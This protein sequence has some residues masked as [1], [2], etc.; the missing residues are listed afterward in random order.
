MTSL[1]AAPSVWLPP[2]VQEPR[3]RCVPTC[4]A[5]AG[6]EA[7]Q[8]YE[9][10]GQS[11]DQWQ[12]SALIDACGE[13]EDGRWAS[14]EVGLEVARQ[15]GKDE[16]LAARE[17]AGLFVWGERLLVHSAHKFDT[18]MEHLE[19]LATLIEGAPDFSRRVR[20]VN[21]S[22][23]SEGITLMDGA[24]IRFR[25][26]TRGGGARGYTGDC[27]IFNEA[28]DLPDA[29]IGAIMPILSARSVRI[30][31]PQIWLAG[32]AVD[33]ETMANGLVLARVR[34]AGIA[35]D[36]ERLTYL[37]YS[38]SLIDWMRA[39]G[40]E[41]DPDRGSELEQ[42]TPA[43]LADPEMWAQANP[44]LGKRI[45]HEHVATELRS[46]SMTARQFAIERLGV[47]DWPEITD[48][49][50][51]VITVEKW[52]ACACTDETK[53]IEGVK[54]FAVDVNPSRTWGSL[55]VAGRREDLVLADGIERAQ[56]H[57]AI[58][59]HERQTD[60]II[61]KEPDGTY[62]G[63]AVELNEEHEGCRFVMDPYGPAA[64]LI[65]LMKEAGLEVIETA[66]RDYANACGG[67]FDAVDQVRVRYPVPQPDLDEA[68]ASART[69]TLGD[70]WKWAPRSSTSADITPLVAGT[71]ALW[72]AETQVVADPE[73]LIAWR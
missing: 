62:A 1:L 45:S 58:I 60:W 64:T 44:A 12:Q 32:S 73:P 13:R 40:L 11:L 54:T 42:V 67:F 24:R 22:H 61:R 29:L 48:G 25:A 46:P 20:K 14:F 3:I 43:F 65:P 10:T 70:A 21:R 9:L 57:L 38:A 6:I 5:S 33:Q 72:G 19:R 66:T 8:A 52:L 30:P 71:L 2:G 37:E 16:I 50:S 15:N 56:Y 23:G 34:L 47:G 26:R 36:N 18:A 49:A 51:R 35:G 27:V 17:L 41:F 4:V 53:R 68:V 31:G 39:H 55:A 28:M 69:T 7:V 59:R 63:L